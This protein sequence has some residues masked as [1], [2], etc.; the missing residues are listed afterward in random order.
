MSDTSQIDSRHT[1]H[2]QL[3]LSLAQKSSPKP[4]NYC[5]GALLVDPKEN[6]ILATGFTSEC[7]G[8]THAEQCCFIKLAAEHKI[9]EERVGDILPEGCVLYTTVEPCSERLSGNLP[10]VDR[11]LRTQIGRKGITKVYVG[12]KEPKEFVNSNT[13]AKKLEENGIEC[14]HVPG[15]EEDIL[16]TASAGHVH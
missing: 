1:R 4:T 3:A 13:A 6:R 12:I 5:V 10:C 9:A 16:S 11:I 14:I 15:L 8:N 7:P 2:M